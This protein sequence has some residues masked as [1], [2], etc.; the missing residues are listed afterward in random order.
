MSPAFLQVAE[1]LPA[2]GKQQMYSLFCFACTHTF[3]LF[4]FIS[5]YE[6]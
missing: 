3:A 2:N 4:V 5:T 1:E 6:F